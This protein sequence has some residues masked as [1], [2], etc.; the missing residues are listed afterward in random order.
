MPQLIFEGDGA[1]STTPPAAGRIFIDTTNEVVYMSVGSASPDDWVKTGEK[2]AS[3]ELASFGD[4]VFDVVDP[5]ATITDASPAGNDGGLTGFSFEDA[6]KTRE[7]DGSGEYGGIRLSFGVVG[8]EAEDVMTP[9]S[10]DGILLESYF[11][12][13]AFPTNTGSPYFK[14]IRVEAGSTDIE[15]RLNIGTTSPV[16]SLR[17]DSAGGDSPNEDV[18]AAATTA[19][20]LRD[21]GGTLTYLPLWHVMHVR[22]ANDQA[23]L[24]LNGAALAT[25]PFS[26]GLDLASA[27]NLIVQSSEL[28]GSPVM[29]KFRAFEIVGDM[30]D[31][32]IAAR[33]ANFDIGFF[34]DGFTLPDGYVASSDLANL[35]EL[36]VDGAAR[37][38]VVS[39]SAAHEAPDASSGDIEQKRGAFRVNVTNGSD[40]EIVLN[41]EA[42][43]LNTRFTVR[44]VD[45]LNG[46][47][48]VANESLSLSGE[49]DTTST[50]TVPFTA[51]STGDLFVEVSTDPD[52]ATNFNDYRGITGKYS[53]SAVSA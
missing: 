50:L 23:T 3:F 19:G 5:G 40:Y 52:D 38:G 44:V 45:Q 21:A 48:E 49:A 43:P 42:N 27:A 28:N 12:A 6:G 18:T 11:F 14:P 41:T 9:Q 51:P 31:A 20:M 8:F 34:D 33:A 39:F 4:Y 53:V 17:G 37:D 36:V 25:V 15:V 22:L 32:E 46:D 29:G 2:P 16:V 13:S 7:I 35:T 30:L 47:S 10:P 24:F 26:G 1:P